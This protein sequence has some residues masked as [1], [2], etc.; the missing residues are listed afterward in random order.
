MFCGQTRRHL[1][2]G[3]ALTGATDRSPACA[4]SGKTSGPVAWFVNISNTY[5]TNSSQ[6]N[7]PY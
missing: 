4:A 3:A 1:P 7:C 5:H 2:G 6:Y